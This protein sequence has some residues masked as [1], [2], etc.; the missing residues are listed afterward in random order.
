MSNISRFS[1]YTLD[2]LVEYIEKL[3]CE[4]MRLRQVAGVRKQLRIEDT[5]LSGRT[6]SRL[7]FADI[8]FLTDLTKFSKDDLL[9]LRG[10]GNKMVSEIEEVLTKHGLKL[11]L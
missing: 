6:V 2:Q 3:E 8:V 11:S 9:K 7:V 4:N 5:E 10:V 1:H